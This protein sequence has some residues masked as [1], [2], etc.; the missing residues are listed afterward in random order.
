MEF[1]YR[2]L[3]LISL[4]LKNNQH[5]L[6]GFLNQFIVLLIGIFIFVNPYPHLTAIREIS[7]YGAFILL[8]VL[9]FFGKTDF[10]LQSPLSIPFLLFL[11]WI[12]IGL[13]FALNKLNSLHDFFVHLVKY[14]FLFYLL[15]NFINNRGRLLVLIWTIILS[16]T[17]YAAG[18]LIYFYV[19]L[20]NDISTKL[21]VYGAYN[22]QYQ[23]E[24]PSNIIGISTLFAM[25]L[26]L[27][28]LSREK[29]GY[30]KLVLCI[31]VF[32]TAIA[33]L[34][35]QTRGALL[36]MIVALLLLF[37]KN[38]KMTIIFCLFL[39]TFLAIMPVR[40][41]LTP[42]A[43]IYKIA[44]DERWK[45]WY[46]FGKM[47]RDYPITGIG[48]GMRTYFDE[49]LLEKYREE[50]PAAYRTRELFN[51]PHNLLVDIAVRTGLIGLFLFLCVVCKY[52]QISWK[53]IKYGKDP[54]IKSWGLCFLATFTAVFIQG[55]FENT[56]SGPPAIILYTI[57]GLTTIVW[58]INVEPNKDDHTTA[59]S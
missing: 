51:A 29:I 33:T 56:M 18:M 41:I 44:E 19:M 23:S 30:R 20:G 37:L 22:Y 3:S 27:Q 53:I 54:F 16:T 8:S 49:K 50:V 42:Q 6:T 34:A 35:T 15:I 5:V 2:Y 9:I 47:V 40:N 52:L 25:I 14:M 43:V 58:K 7:I 55:L 10:S 39:A 31:C 48:F 11:L 24:I 12:F 32:M 28:Q 21:G 26:S 46:F 59:V 17:L 38:K 1:L 36:A 57:F 13:F 45:A 4:S